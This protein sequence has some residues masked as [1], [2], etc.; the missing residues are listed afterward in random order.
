M[1]ITV[2]KKF[3]PGSYYIG[4]GTALGNPFVMNGEAERNFVCDQYELYFQG[5]LFDND[6]AFMKELNRLY[7][8]A[9]SKDIVL[10]CFCSPKRCHGDTIKRY[11]DKLL[12][13][14]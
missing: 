8:A 6:P 13:S 9:K 11:L 12:L 2:G 3:V 10:G 4:R 1:A 14:A 5:K 7:Q